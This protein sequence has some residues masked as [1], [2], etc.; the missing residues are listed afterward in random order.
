MVTLDIGGNDLLYLAASEPC[1]SAPNGGACRQAVI[2]TLAGYE[3]NYRSIVS[4]LAEALGVSAPTARFI[5]VTYYNPFSGTGHEI[6]RA[7][8]LALL[9]DDRAMD[10]RAATNPDNRGMN[11]IVA[12][13]ASELST[14]DL[15]VE[16]ADV[17]PD[18]I[19]RGVELTLIEY[20]DIHAN[21]A[22]YAVMAERVAQ[23]YRSG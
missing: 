21:D 1:V 9:G 20:G 15:S 23:V 8:E 5:V 13:V 14:P 19:G 6:E 11:D 4:T 22:G 7:G 10:C 16:V 3:A 18:F 17:Q 12:C 2:A